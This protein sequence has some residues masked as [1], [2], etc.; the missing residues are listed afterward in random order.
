MCDVAVF[1][2]HSHVNSK[3]TVTRQAQPPLGLIV[4]Y[5]VGRLYRSLPGKMSHN[6]HKQD[7]EPFRNLADKILRRRGLDHTEKI[8]GAVLAHSKFGQAVN[9]CIRTRVPGCLFDCLASPQPGWDQIQEY[10]S[11]LGY[12]RNVSM[13]NKAQSA[14]AWIESVMK[15][16][17]VS[18]GPIIQFVDVQARDTSFWRLPID[19]P[20]RRRHAYE[21]ARDRSL[22]NRYG[23]AT[24]GID[25]VF[26]S[27][28]I[29]LLFDN[30]RWPLVCYNAAHEGWTN[31]INWRREHG[32]SQIS[33]LIAKLMRHKH[34][35][36]VGLSHV[37]DTTTANDQLVDSNGFINLNVLLSFMQTEYADG[38]MF[39]TALSL[40]QCLSFNS[41]PRAV[42]LAMFDGTWHEFTNMLTV[43][44]WN[45]G[46]PTIKSVDSIEFYLAV[47]QGGSLGHGM[48]NNSVYLTEGNWPL[49]KKWY[50]ERF[51]G[52][53][54]EEIIILHGCE[55]HSGMD[56]LRDGMIPGH[57]LF[58]RGREDTHFVYLH[59]SDVG[60]NRCAIHQSRCWV[61]AV[62]FQMVLDQCGIIVTS[63]GCAGSS[64][65]ISPRRL[66]VMDMERGLK[67]LRNGSTEPLVGPYLEIWRKEQ[68][69]RREEAQQP[70][71]LVSIGTYGNG[72]FYAQCPLRAQPYDATT[73]TDELLNKNPPKIY[74]YPQGP[75]W[76]AST[77]MTPEART[78]AGPKLPPPP[79]PP[80][81]PS[82]LLQ[83]S[84]L[85][86]G[87]KRLITSTGPSAK[88]KVAASAK[89]AAPLPGSREWL[90]LAA[91]TS[92]KAPER[93]LPSPPARMVTRPEMVDAEQQTVETE[94]LTKLNT[95]DKQQ[96]GE[97]SKE[98]TKVS[99]Q[100]REPIDLNQDVEVIEIDLGQSSSSSSA[101][102][103]QTAIASLQIV[104]PEAYVVLQKTAIEAQVNYELKKELRPQMEELACKVDKL[105]L[106]EQLSKAK[107]AEFNP[108]SN[109]TLEDAGTIESETVFEAGLPLPE[110]QRTVSSVLR[111]ANTQKP[112]AR[113][114]LG[115]PRWTR[116]ELSVDAS[117]ADSEPQLAET[118]KMTTAIVQ[119]LSKKAS[120]GLQPTNKIPE[121]PA[122]ERLERI[123]H[124]R[125]SS[126][127]GMSISPRQTQPSHLDGDAMSIASGVT[128]DQEGRMAIEAA[129]DSPT[130]GSEPEMEDGSPQLNDEEGRALMVRPEEVETSLQARTLPAVAEENESEE[131]AA[132]ED[133]Q[134]II[135]YTRMRTFVDNVEIALASDIFSRVPTPPDSDNEYTDES[136]EPDWE[137]INERKALRRWRILRQ[138]GADTEARSSWSL[139][140]KVLDELTTRFKKT[141]QRAQ[142]L[143]SLMQLSSFKDIEEWYVWKQLDMCRKTP[144]QQILCQG[145][146]N[147]HFSKDDHQ[148]LVLESI[149]NLL[150]VDTVAIMT[151]S[152]NPM[153][154]LEYRLHPDTYN[155]VTLLQLII[156]NDRTDCDTVKMRPREVLYFWRFDCKNAAIQQSLQKADVPEDVLQTMKKMHQLRFAVSL[157][158]DSM[159]RA[160]SADQN[161]VLTQKDWISEQAVTVRTQH[162][163]S[164][165]LALVE[166]IAKL[167]DHAALQ[168]HGYRL[169]QA[170]AIQLR[171]ELEDVPALSFTDSTAIPS[172]PA[173]PHHNEDWRQDKAFPLLDPT[174]M[175][176]QRNI[177]RSTANQR[178]A[179]ERARKVINMEPHT[180]FE[181]LQ[182][183]ANAVH[184][185]EPDEA[186]PE[187]IVDV[188]RIQE[189]A[190]ETALAGLAN[191]ITTLDANRQKLSLVAKLLEPDPQQENQ[192]LETH[193]YFCLQSI[194]TDYERM[195]KTARELWFA[196]LVHK[197]LNA[198]HHLD[199]IEYI[200]YHFC[201]GME[202][203][204]ESQETDG[205]IMDLT[206]MFRKADGYVNN[207]RS[208][209]DR[210]QL[211]ISYVITRYMFTAAKVKMDNNRW[212]DMS[213]DDRFQYWFTSAVILKIDLLHPEFWLEFEIMHDRCRASSDAN[214]AVAFTGAAPSADLRTH[215]LVTAS[216]VLAVKQIQL[217]RNTMQDFVFRQYLRQQKAYW[218]SVG[219]YASTGVSVEIKTYMKNWES[220]RFMSRDQCLAAPKCLAL[221]RSEWDMGDL[222]EWTELLP[223]TTQDR[224]GHFQE[225]FRRADKNLGTAEWPA[226][227][228]LLHLHTHQLN[229]VPGEF[230]MTL[231]PEDIPNIISKWSHPKDVFEPFRDVIL[232]KAF[233]IFWAQH[234][235]HLKH[236]C[237]KAKKKPGPEGWPKQPTGT[238]SVKTFD[239]WCYDYGYHGLGAILGKINPKTKYSVVKN[240]FLKVLAVRFL[241]HELFLDPVNDLKINAEKAGD[242]LEATFGYA[243][244]LGYFSYCSAL[245]VLAVQVQTATPEELNLGDLHEFWVKGTY[246]T[247]VDIDVSVYPSH[248]TWKQSKIDLT[249]DMQKRSVAYNPAEIKRQ[250][251]N[252][253]NV[254]ATTLNNKNVADEQ[255]YVAVHVAATG[256]C[257][258]SSAGQPEIQQL[259]ERTVR[260]KDTKVQ[261]VDYT[262]ARTEK[263]AQILR[264]N[265]CM[266]MDKPEVMSFV[267]S[268][269]S[270]YK[271]P[272]VQ[273]PAAWTPEL[274]RAL[275]KH[276][277]R[278][279]EFRAILDA[280]IT[281]NDMAHSIAEESGRGGAITR[282]LE[283]N[284]VYEQKQL[285]REQ[286]FA[287]ARNPQLFWN[288]EDLDDP[289]ERHKSDVTEIQSP[290]FQ[291]AFFNMKS[292][293][294]NEVL[295]AVSNFLMRTSAHIVIISNF[296]AMF[297]SADE[298]VNTFRRRL[299]AQTN[300]RHVYVQHPHVL[301]LQ[302]KAMAFVE[303]WIA[304]MDRSLMHCV[305]DVVL[306]TIKLPFYMRTQDADGKWHHSGHLTYSEGEEWLR[307]NGYTKESDNWGNI[308]NQEGPIEA[309]TA[310]GTQVLRVSVADIDVEA[311]I[312]NNLL[313]PNGCLIQAG[314]INEPVL[315]LS[316]EE[317]QAA[318]SYVLRRYA[319]SDINC[320]FNWF[321]C[322][323]VSIV[324]WNFPESL[325]YTEDLKT[326]RLDDTSNAFDKTKSMLNTIMAEARETINSKRCWQTQINVQIVTQCLDS[327]MQARHD[328]QTVEPDCIGYIPSRPLC[329]LHFSISVSE[330]A[331]RARTTT[332]KTF[333]KIVLEKID[334][335]RLSNIELAQL[336]F[337]VYN[338]REDILIATKLNEN[339]ANPNYTRQQRQL[340]I[341]SIQALKDQE[342]IW[343]VQ[344]PDEITENADNLT[345]DF[346]P[347]DVTITFQKTILPK[348]L[349]NKFFQS[350]AK[351][352]DYLG[353]SGVIGVH[354]KQVQP[355]DYRAIRLRSTGRL[356]DAGVYQ[357]P[358]PWQTHTAGGQGYLERGVRNTPKYRPCDDDSN[359][360]AVMQDENEQERR[361]PDYTWIRNHPSPQ[362]SQDVRVR[363]DFAEFTE[364]RRT[365]SYSSSSWHEPTQWPSSASSSQRRDNRGARQDDF[366]SQHRTRERW[367]TRDWKSSHHPR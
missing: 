142:K 201:L 289:P 66:Q 271:L 85:S 356:D 40:V 23:L 362:T 256:A 193:S 174:P 355:A 101:S 1:L 74:R 124:S 20:E 338:M 298:A 30:R 176:R 106:T 354:I 153:E 77:P 294:K 13:G 286:W 262:R 317:H 222:S 76:K 363:T 215:A 184:E 34:H 344:H 157:N 352:S 73:W 161:V 339:G 146:L 78:K 269:F 198:H 110:Q 24:L 44:V 133:E 314:I 90:N 58:S 127:G 128:S 107:L 155:E 57:K 243:F 31:E 275:H 209:M 192:K 71:G 322:M 39:Y 292:Y 11:V 244:E 231:T 310:Q 280:T 79:L 332:L 32:W 64:S 232:I 260:V 306:F 25:K 228:N 343:E 152:S 177:N 104:K 187:F 102:C 234:D 223:D 220:L 195:D 70:S 52:R 80:Q 160:L 7:A 246:S 241:F 170:D 164:S 151:M 330:E 301:I 97:L 18:A 221:M 8:K 140:Q 199:M 149:F 358:G 258:T 139:G 81:P 22:C 319:T 172:E 205:I 283:R 69:R 120:R 328:G 189:L 114:T 169:L 267:M 41:K 173:L 131:R 288:P 224:L 150:D 145:Y 321:N 333:Q 84:E 225:S 111:E 210:H 54:A 63:T 351:S 331:V 293:Q 185:V 17:G 359:P 323:E 94:V 75:G 320:V 304:K 329:L 213:Y 132:E 159:M 324:G 82:R 67:C 367:D 33:R 251:S 45:N 266:I 156:E 335:E 252:H 60:M 51:P 309:M 350:C 103:S 14:N 366:A 261:V 163:N 55:H 168:A 342:C 263:M 123:V 158:E 212:T 303:V 287:N 327:H 49:F 137:K 299:R 345:N 200:K 346:G 255:K 204:I 334:V 130:S 276:V 264:D 206:K 16:H 122:R 29:S 337:Y 196:W 307:D 272:G 259:R 72:Q 88:A 349:Y 135:S 227:I 270:D 296:D 208:E 148:R 300:E 203:T 178:A 83:E 68:R 91:M 162:E 268:V 27:E 165:L 89:I 240:D 112:T 59:P 5:L 357:L 171:V 211:F 279:A 214:G 167:P 15:D 105:Y 121:G 326:T 36:S 188:H 253:L 360:F 129:T 48:H 265:E 19:T 277:S 347:L 239:A 92:P 336:N 125:S 96:Y 4:S 87:V 65:N 230:A 365:T 249:V 166:V 254:A 197:K 47:P 191:V 10:G 238:C 118:T 6:R 250:L 236:I 35:F 278:T 318:V 108:K 207:L 237:L 143:R 175:R 247:T 182:A 364:R 194:K 43:G 235:D 186:S 273:D 9:V 115:V 113:F 62:L 86:Q 305:N 100:D 229:M 12:V 281:M 295:T 315:S 183:I 181:T 26:K 274:Q 218:G 226:I 248:I 28:L 353:F 291:V 141:F 95:K 147:R 46:W 302:W 93:D 56:I 312:E 99:K 38:E 179:I 98:V 361:E 297:S 50:E 138:L 119:G 126:S 348:S 217:E 53:N 109:D 3:I 42:L 233:L 61:A 285:R 311:T 325:Q 282:E 340:R 308:L 313:E 21:Y 134:G 245:M 257:N 290:C 190:S 341:R 116:R 2:C 37:H 136:G 202:S 117:V 216:N 316:D 154:F 284:R 144:S 180:R 219:E 242:I